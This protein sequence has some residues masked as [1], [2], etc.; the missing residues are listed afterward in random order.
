MKIYV[1]KI[2]DRHY[3]PEVH[4]YATPEAAIEYARTW[5]KNRAG[6]ADDV[7]ETPVDGWVYHAIC[8]P[9]GDRVWI[10]E[11]TVDDM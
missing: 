4:L 6:C 10:T 5:A 9:E 8:T 2:Y 11:T 1:V 3:D 7:D